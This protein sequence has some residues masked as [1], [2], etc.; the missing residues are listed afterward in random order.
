VADDLLVTPLAGP[1]RRD[2]GMLIDLSCIALL[3]QI[4]SLVLTVIAAW[5]F[6]KQ[7]TA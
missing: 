4:S 2:F 7:V 6:L 5:T 1:F 3:T